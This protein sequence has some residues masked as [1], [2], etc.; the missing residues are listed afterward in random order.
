MNWYYAR[1]DER[2]GPVDQDEFEQLVASGVITADT[3]VWCAGMPDWQPLDQTPG[4]PGPDTR[5]ADIMAPGFEP[6]H[7][8]ACVE[9]GR[10]FPTADMVAYEGHY[11]CAECKPFFFQRLREGERLPGQMR[12][13]G[14]WIRF[15]ARFVDGI[16]LGVVNIPLSILQN[17]LISRGIDSPEDPEDLA[18]VF[19]IA[20]IFWLLS[21]LLGL[22]YETWFVG[23]FAAT[24]GK[25][26]CGLKVV[27]S[28]GGKVSYARAGGRY[29]G[30]M[31]SSMTLMIGYI[32]AAFDSEKRA[33]HDHICDTRVVHK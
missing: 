30:T 23:R 19:M 12:F 11:V 20:A 33:L 18:L 29:L 25:M 31:L 10:G 3:L 8:Q 24:P 16:I 2:M 26:A 6:G 9:C 17:V 13:G 1:G 4:A 14:F 27:M 22:A 21:I 28:D 7:V 32:I 15:V 5:G